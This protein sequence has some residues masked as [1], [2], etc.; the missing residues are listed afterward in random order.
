[1]RWIEG[2][3]TARPAIASKHGLRRRLLGR[4]RAHLRGDQLTGAIQ[5]RRLDVGA[6]DVDG[7]RIGGARRIAG[8]YAEVSVAA[9]DIRCGPLACGAPRSQAPSMP[10]EC[11]DVVP[12]TVVSRRRTIGKS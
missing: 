7:E 6:A 1:M 2:S 11:A 3:C 5:H 12:T 8:A 9:V 10:D 4:G